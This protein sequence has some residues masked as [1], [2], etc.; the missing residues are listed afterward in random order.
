MTGPEVKL[1]F[2][3]LAISHWNENY[4]VSWYDK[5]DDNV[6]TESSP[7]VYK[8]TLAESTP[9][10]IRVMVY[11]KRMYPFSCKQD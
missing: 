10:S 9:L 5:K 8:F 4:Q 1:A 7:A 2:E 3:E 11:N 6:A